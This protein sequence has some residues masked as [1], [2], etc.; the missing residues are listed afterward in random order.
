MKLLDSAERLLV[1]LGWCHRRAWVFPRGSGCQL[2]DGTGGSSCLTLG[3]GGRVVGYVG[4]AEAER[5]YIRLRAGHL[6]RLP[7]CSTLHHSSDSTQLAHGL[8]WD[9]QD[10]LRSNFR[11][12]LLAL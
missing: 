4:E 2:A 8:R 3:G 12:A 6:P 5:G 10:D 9:D 11:V 1:T 7:R